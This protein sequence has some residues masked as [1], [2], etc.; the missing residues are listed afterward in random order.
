MSIRSL[1]Q[2]DPIGLAGGLNLYGFAEGDPANLGDPFGLKCV[3]VKY[4]EIELKQGGMSVQV[5]VLHTGV[6]WICDH[7]K[8]ISKEK[9]GDDIVIHL[10]GDAGAGESS[11]PDS[12]DPDY[13][14]TE[15]EETHFCSLASRSVQVGSATYMGGAALMAT[16]VG[17]KRK[18]KW[19][20]FNL[21]AARGAVRLMI[22]G[23]EEAT[24]G[25]QAFQALGCAPN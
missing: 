20:P 2:E 5:T 11:D 19:W 15:A 25:Y 17:L 3:P 23:A 9:T 24:I 13:V 6:I 21:G 14:P 16:S 7:S 8:G 22:K 10:P 12:R 4:Q 18:S 1:T